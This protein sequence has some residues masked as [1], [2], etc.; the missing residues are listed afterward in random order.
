MEDE[1]RNIHIYNKKVE[2]CKINRFCGRVTVEER[3]DSAHTIILL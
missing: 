1:K 3:T 2:I